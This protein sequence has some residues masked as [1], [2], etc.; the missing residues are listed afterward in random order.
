[1]RVERGRDFG[2]KWNSGDGSSV[3]IGQ[4]E[5]EDY[6]YGIPGRGYIKFCRD[7]GRKKGTATVDWDS[8]KHSDGIAP[9][10]DHHI[11]GEVN[12]MKRYDLH[13]VDENGK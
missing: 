1:M 2:K 12:G 9:T 5:F 10:D 11:G 13:I 6:H 8:G 3:W 4:G 7:S